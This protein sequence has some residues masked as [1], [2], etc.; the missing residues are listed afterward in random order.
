[1]I[2]VEFMDPEGKPLFQPVSLPIEQLPASFELDTQMHLGDQDFEVVRAEPARPDQVAP[3]GSLRLW[4]RRVH[5]IDPGELLYSLCTLNDTLPETPSPEPQGRVFRL[6]EDD[7]RQAEWISSAKREAIELELEDI[8]RI[9]T[10]HRVGVGFDQLHIRRRIE[11]PLAGVS[12]RLPELRELLPESFAG[13]GFLNTS[14]CVEN[15][16]A[17]GDGPLIYG[18]APR[19]RVEVLCLGHPRREDLVRLAERWPDEVVW[20]DWCRGVCLPPRE[21]A[22]QFG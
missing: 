14:G 19:D 8:R 5:A 6:H 2:R 7:W 1:M 18:I 17:L 15:G 13:L 16:F 12:I 4:L 11:Q 21:A 9:Q 3:G 20:V 10:E 22:Q